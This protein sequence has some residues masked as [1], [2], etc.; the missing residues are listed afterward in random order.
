MLTPT[1]V[2]VSVPNDHRLEPNQ[3][4]IKRGIIDGIRSAGFEPQEL[5]ASGGFSQIPWSYENV[6]YK[7][8]RCQGAVILGL[9][10]WDVWDAQNKYRFNTAYNH[11]EGALALAK[12]IPAFILMHEHIHKAGIALKGRS[13][14]F[15]KLPDGVNSSWLQTDEF[16]STF[17][18][19]VDAVKNRRH[20]FLGYGGKA[21]ATATQIKDFLTNKGVSVMEAVVD[22]NAA[23]P[24]MDKIEQASKSCLGGIFL[25]TKDD[26]TI[27]ADTI[28]AAPRDNVIFEAGYFMHAKGTDRT[29]IIM[30]EGAKAPFDTGGQGYIR[31]QD[32]DDI[33]PIEKDLENFIVKN[34]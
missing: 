30:E 26:E 14:Y 13:R 24:G 2:Y 10:R 9:V 31:L 12:D 8:G 3:L 11:Y 5:F 15:V 25:F 21:Q 19:W 32:R 20:I 23:H 17:S 1:R 18:G 27:T 34:L 22:F 16:M 7:L 33:S 6:Q 4:E 28:S 29:L